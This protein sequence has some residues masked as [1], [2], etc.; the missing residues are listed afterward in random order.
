M[1]EHRRVPFRGP[2]LDDICPEETGYVSHTDAI[3]QTD[4]PSGQQTRFANGRLFIPEGIPFSRK[5]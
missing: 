2:V 5:I 3:F 1:E 4:R